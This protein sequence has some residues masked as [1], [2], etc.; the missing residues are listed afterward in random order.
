MC[1]VK[2]DPNGYLELDK[3]NDFNS[4][5]C[6]VSDSN[7]IQKP[8]SPYAST[9]LIIRTWI[10]WYQSAKLQSGYWWW[11]HLLSRP[12]IGQLFLWKDCCVHRVREKLQFLQNTLWLQQNCHTSTCP[13]LHKGWGPL[14][15]LT[16][17]DLRSIGEKSK[18]SQKTGLFQRYL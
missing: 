12:V 15:Y 17:S 10:Y 9:T 5:C 18:N 11:Q 8:P 1:D 13:Q 2:H 3:K 16:N 4:Q 6:E 14:L 7:T